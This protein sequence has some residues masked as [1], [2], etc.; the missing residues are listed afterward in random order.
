MDSKGGG[1]RAGRSDSSGGTDL[2]AAT[3]VAGE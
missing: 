2:E 1:C 3:V